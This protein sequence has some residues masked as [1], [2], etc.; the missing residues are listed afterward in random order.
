MY[1]S[2]SG[3]TPEEPVISRK[4]GHL[5]EKRLIEKYI[6]ATGKCPVSG[7]ELSKDD[8]LPVK[9]NPVI[10]PRPAS[11]LSIPGLLASLQT[12]WDSL[13]LETHTLRTHLETV[14]QE[15]SHALYQHDAACRV[16][17]RLIKERDAA[18]EA[19][20]RGGQISIQTAPA[21][22]AAETNKM[23]V[24]TG[25]AAP[26]G[27]LPAELLSAMQAEAKTLLKS[28]K[29]RPLPP[30]LARAEAVQQYSEIASHPLHK[31]TAPGI[32]SLS[33]DAKNENVV[34]TGG[35]DKEAILFDRSSG[36]ILTTLKGHKKAVHHVDI[37]PTQDLLLTCSNAVKIWAPAEAAEGKINYSAKFSLEH[38]T[39]DVVDSHFQPMRQH[40]AAVSRDATW[41]MADLA[42]GT[43]LC[44]VKD[45]NYGSAGFAG[46]TCVQFHPDGLVLATGTSDARIRLWDMQD[47]ENAMTLE[48]HSG[49]IRALSFSE[50]GYFLATA[51][52][53][54][55]K[56]WDLRK[57]SNFRTINVDEGNV[58]SVQ[59]D[60]SGQYLSYGTTTGMVGVLDSA[61]WGRLR[62]FH[63][64]TD[65]VTSLKWGPDAKYLVSS[66]LD[67]N[68]KV[69]S[70]RA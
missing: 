53:S 40:F 63:D 60:Y 31:T 8:L 12:E 51:A 34:L 59:F 16:I 35:K 50:N 62:T 54:T 2:I 14:R 64:H 52:D 15:L 33:L 6:D 48:G 30:G 23:E 9:T 66:S 44:Q 45:P 67:R 70:T 49:A 57:F 1:C 69:Y 10:K 38:H 46:Y 47:L 68:L 17:A 18:R 41:S 21:A 61:Q 56:L 36:K 55:V 26:T 11:A 25:A 5:F 20:A 22:A 58:T 39:D 65:E 13:M 27:R 37:H 29:K 3:Q 24:D 43:V 19:L 32:L 7:E 4:T 42:T 28:R